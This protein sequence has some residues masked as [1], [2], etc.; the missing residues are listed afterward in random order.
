MEKLLRQ[1]DGMKNELLR[2]RQVSREQADVLIGY[3]ARLEAKKNE[4]KSESAC[5]MSLIFCPQSCDLDES[6]KSAQA[7]TEVISQLR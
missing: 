5:R 2:L 1:S 3:E 7:F 6:R 4:V